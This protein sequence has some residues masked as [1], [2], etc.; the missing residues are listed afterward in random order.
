MESNSIA[1]AD[2]RTPS[3]SLAAAIDRSGGQPIAVDRAAAVSEQ[4]AAIVA[5]DLESSL[6]A[7]TKNPELLREVGPDLN[8]EQQG[9]LAGIERATQRMGRLLTSVRNLAHASVELER[10]PLDAVIEEVLET[11]APIAAERSAEV[12]IHTPLPTVIGDR[13]Q[14]VQLFQNLVLNAIKY[15]PQRRGRVTISAKRMPGAWQISVADQ[16][17]GIAPE[18]RTRVFEPFYRVLG[19]HKQPG[20]GLGLS[21]CQR[22]AENH[23]GSLIV[24]PST[25]GRGSTFLFT[26]PDRTLAPDGSGNGAAERSGNRAGTSAGNG[27]FAPPSNGAALRR[28]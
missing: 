5:H 14:L 26:L 19:A 23:S 3:I 4:F 8:A 13:S 10:V 6:L 25:G 22:V 1:R 24:Q 11:L 16:G 28:A 7:L 27:A 21:I 2:E 15:G 12:V 20:T 9:H 17:P 18:N